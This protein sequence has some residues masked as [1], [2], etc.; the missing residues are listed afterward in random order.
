MTVIV[1][2]GGALGLTSYLLVDTKHEL[3][4]TQSKL[5]LEQSSVVTLQNKTTRLEEDIVAVAK[6]Y[7]YDFNARLALHAM[8]E[9]AFWKVAPE[10]Q[11][12]VTRVWDGGPKVTFQKIT[13]DQGSGSEMRMTNQRVPGH[14]PVPREEWKSKGI[15]VTFSPE[16]REQFPGLAEAEQIFYIICQ[17]PAWTCP[18]N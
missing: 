4:T 8:L 16:F 18:N 1:L 15:L 14:Q 2:V 11:T 6:G 17:L 9:L 10:G 7:S 5:K 13:R 3:V 12:V